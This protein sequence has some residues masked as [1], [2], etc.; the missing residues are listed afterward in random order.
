[1]S[2]DV[3]LNSFVYLVKSPLFYFW[4]QH[5]LREK[6][7]FISF[8]VLLKF[9]LWRLLL[10]Y[11]FGEIGF[12]E[13]PKLFNDKLSLETTE[14][15]KSEKE[16]KEKKRFYLLRHWEREINKRLMNQK[17]LKEKNDK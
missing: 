6:S 3:T 5:V 16:E 10:R 14:L 13:N 8:Q 1:M 11:R 17:R 7:F 9:E 2:L 15:I 4:F 12:K